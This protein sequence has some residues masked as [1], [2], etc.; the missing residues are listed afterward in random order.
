MWPI[1][2]YISGFTIV[3]YV[4]FQQG[5]PTSVLEVESVLR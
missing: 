3:F 1:F 2:K 5:D 4:I